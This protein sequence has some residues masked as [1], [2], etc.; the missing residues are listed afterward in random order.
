MSVLGDKSAT[1]KAESYNRRVGNSREIKGVFHTTISDTAFFDIINLLDYIDF[2]NLEDNYSVGRTD[3][4]TSV[5]TV[6]YNNGK[7]K[8]I[9]DYG[10]VGTFGLDRLYHLFFNLR[11]NQNWK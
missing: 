9:R 8:T 2:P 5:L 3:D 7:V 11:Y 1:F 4:Q 10:L 6:T